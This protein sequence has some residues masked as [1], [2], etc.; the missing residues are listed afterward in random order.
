[1]PRRARRSHCRVAQAGSLAQAMRTSI[2]LR[3]NAATLRAAVAEEVVAAWAAVVGA[4]A[5]ARMNIMRNS[6]LI[7]LSLCFAASCATPRTS[8]ASPQAAVQALVDSAH[9][10]KLTE[11]LLGPGGFEMLRSGDP[12]ADRR[13][14]ALVRELIQQKV[15]FVEQRDG[16]M[17]AMLGKDAWPL[18]L[19]LVREGKGWCFDVEAGREEM[20]RRRI[21]RNELYA[22]AALRACVVAQ[23]EYAAVGRDGNAASFA[24]AFRSSPGR[25]D[26]LHW[27]ATV[28][29]PASPLGELLA[30][31]ADAKAFHGY[32]FRILTAQGKAAPGGAR[33]Y[34]DAQGVLRTGFAVVAWPESY[35]ETGIKTFVVNQQGIVFESDLG[36]GGAAEVQ[37]YNPDESWDPVR[38]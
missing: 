26:G 20:L 16:V 33:S 6:L 13:D 19:P 3:A 32:R 38:G 29:Q 5:S 22:I 9:D 24:R 31:A 10:P 8:F 18:P 30:D 12:E 34:L 27:P 15:D 37:A 11:Q 17:I 2:A 4:E 21:G 7:V 28:G 23:H 35:G 14:V 36:S 1:M 25:H